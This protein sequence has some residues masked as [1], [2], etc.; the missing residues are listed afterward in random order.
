MIR[1]SVF[2]A[3]ALAFVSAAAPAQQRL[4]V[5]VDPRI[6]LVSAVEILTEQFGNLVSSSDTDYR[7]DLL[8]RFLPFKDHPAV[9]R[10][11]QLAGNGF[12]Y[13]APMQ[14]M[15]CLSPPPELEWKAKPEECS[16]ERAGG[17]DSLRAWA[18]Q[19]RD[20]ARKSDFAAFF[21]AHSDLYARMVEGARS[22]APHDYAADLEDY[23]GE[24]QAS[25]TVVLA[26][27]LAKG[28]YGV[29][30]KRADAS[31]DIYGIIS[32]VNVSDG[33][34]QFGGEENLRYMVWHEFSH[35]FVNP[36]FDR[37]PGA[38]E[39]SGKLMGPI[40]KQM[41]SQAYPDWKI[42]VNEH[43]VRAVTSRLA[44]RILGDAAGQATLERERAR[45]FAYVE[46]LAG[47]L[48]EYE[49][50]RQRYPT[51]HDF[52]PQLVAVLDG[53]AALNL[54]PEFY[55]TPFTGTIESA[56]RESGPTVLIVPTAETDGAAQRDLVVYVKRV[57]A[58]VLKDSEMLTDQEAL[59]RDLSK[60]RIFAYGTLAGNLWLARYKDLIPAVPVFAQMKEAGP[61]RLIA[62]MPNPQNSRRGVTAYT[63]TQAAAVIGIHG[64]FHGPTAYVIGKE[65]T[66]LKTG[67]YR[68]EN[69]KWALR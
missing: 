67:D 43:M 40:Q 63:A 1:T 41:A 21:R 18:G 12:N 29:R 35:S 69:G 42:A 48:K 38:V 59:V 5:I 53:L 58:Q 30:V 60:C 22:K 55:E 13:D 33:V 68:Q 32:S 56:Q 45:G 36:E 47:K 44:F 54:P 8:S 10:M 9:A 3:V 57:Q 61:L 50:N 34:A 20:F 25:Y 62:A 24:R 28:N 16:A 51:F 27:L 4:Q 46:A 39:R 7:R 31:L 11:A 49:Q 17:A 2:A 26:P 23:Y 14:T 15:V 6:E 64:L 66:V 65:N 52:A 19:L 37:M